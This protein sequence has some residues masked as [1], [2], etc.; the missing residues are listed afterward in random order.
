MNS[1]ELTEWH[2]PDTNDPNSKFRLY[3]DT[4]LEELPQAHW[5]IDGMVPGGGC[6]VLFGS[7]GSAK[8][9]LAL[10]WALS[11]ATGTAWQGHQVKEGPCVYFAAEGHHGLHNRVRAWKAASGLAS[12]DAIRFIV[13]PVQLHER[14]EV[15][16]VLEAI[17]TLPVPPRL[18]V[19]DTLAR[20]SV[21]L[22][23]NLAKDMGL[24]VRGL[25]Q[26]RRETGATVLLIHH[27]R[28]N[29]QGQAGATLRGS[30]A[31]EGAADVIILSVMNSEDRVTLVCEKQKDAEAFERFVMRLQSVDLDDRG[32][33]SCVLVPSDA[34]VPPKEIAA[35]RALRNLPTGSGSAADWCSASGIGSKRTFYRI[36]KAL[37][38]GGLIEQTGRGAA[39]RYTATACATAKT[40]EADSV[41]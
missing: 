35:L 9:F 28:K 6:A 14:G 33:S 13:G 12:C 24:V 30:S 36:A 16:Q 18:I 25:D 40:D 37:R 23:E 17:E 1:P 7:P 21:G 3:R 2:S 29:Q 11:I 38:K 34:P 19:I 20:C 31:L 22:D 8:T 5:L 41:F 26:I 4:E 32:G 10:D 27:T 15:E 39:T